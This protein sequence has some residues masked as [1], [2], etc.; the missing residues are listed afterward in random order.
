[1]KNFIIKISVFFLF[2]SVFLV[3]IPGCQPEEEVVINYVTEKTGSSSEEEVSETE[4]QVENE[5]QGKDQGESSQDQGQSEDSSKLEFICYFI[6]GNPGKMV[7]NIDLDTN[8][9]Y[10]TLEM[11]SSEIYLEGTNSKVCDFEISGI[12]EGEL[13][14]ENREI[15]AVMNG[16]A[17]SE[18]PTCVGGEIRYDT[19]ATLYENKKFVT[20]EFIT[21][22]LTYEF[23]MERQ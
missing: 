5:Q 14:P 21:S 10:G 9:V 6:G 11:V 12:I 18:S 15:T 1:M 19:V 23:V 3:F 22:T 4:G 2:I 17:R 20:G 16:E 7:L 8:E 13:D